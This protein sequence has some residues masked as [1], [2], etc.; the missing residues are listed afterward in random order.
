LLTLVEQE[1]ELAKVKDD[2]IKLVEE[3]FGTGGDKVMPVSSS[4]LRNVLELALSTESFKEIILFIQYQIG[5]E[6]K[7]WQDFG[8][9]LIDILQQ[10]APEGKDRIERARLFLG[11]L[12][13][14]A[15]YLEKEE[16]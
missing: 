9:K 16:A 14:Y 2:L 3:N 1:H 4:A 8:K 10:A 11:Y 13:R 5:R 12:C 15:K 6:R 7:K